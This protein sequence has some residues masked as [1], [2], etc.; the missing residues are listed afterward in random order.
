MLLSVL[1]LAADLNGIWTGYILNKNGDRID[2]SIQLTQDATGRI[3]GKVYGDYRSNPVVEGQVN[4]EEVTFFV[5]AQEQ[6][7]ASRPQEEH[8][9]TRPPEADRTPPA[10]AP[11]AP[12]F[13]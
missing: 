2:T 13:R 12:R 6:E 8:A 4:G 1:I 11:E 9:L 5:Q 10:R 3:G 7:R